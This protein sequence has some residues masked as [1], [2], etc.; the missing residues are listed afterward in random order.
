MLT[1]VAIA[2]PKPAVRLVDVGAMR[3]V[4]V[5]GE[6]SC[7]H[8]L[9]PA[10]FKLGILIVIL[11]SAAEN[12]RMVSRLQ[13]SNQ[14]REASK[15]AATTSPA[16]ATAHQSSITID[17]LCFCTGRPVDGRAPVTEKVP[18][19]RVVDIGRMPPV[20]MARN[21]LIRWVAFAAASCHRLDFTFR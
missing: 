1:T 18:G 9:L 12:V 21:A 11:E 19:G 15:A 6:G 5:T 13:V 4:A 20:E 2:V 16:F 3:V 14:T 17:S 10:A 8:E 7:G